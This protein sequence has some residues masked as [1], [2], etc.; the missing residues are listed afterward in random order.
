[1]LIRN[2]DFFSFQNKN[3]RLLKQMFNLVICVLV[4]NM[5]AGWLQPAV[6]F[7]GMLDTS[8][9]S[10]CKTIRVQGMI[11]E[12]C[13]CIYCDLIVYLSMKEHCFESLSSNVY[14]KLH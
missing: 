14:R 7:Q 13:D 3:F 10:V 11:V 8:I 9:L 6:P 5:L 2:F 12:E 1:M 4:V